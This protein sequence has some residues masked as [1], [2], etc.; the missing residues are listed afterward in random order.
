MWTIRCL[1]ELDNWDSASFI[2]L[3]YDNEHLP[4]DFSLHPEHLTQ[5]W[6]N[7]RQAI[8]GR[9]IKYYACGEYGE[10]V[11]SLR[12]WIKHGR[13]HMHAIVY[14]LD[15]Y[16]DD[17]RDLVYRC[18]SK[19]EQFMFDKNRKQNGMLPV[20]REDI[21]YTC[22]YVQK[23][24]NG[25]L[26]SEIYGDRKA[27]FSRVSHGIGLDFALKN[28]ERLINNGFTYLNGKKIAV[29][30]YFREKLGMSQ[31]EYLNNNNL[32]LETV[33]HNAAYLWNLFETDQRKKGIWN[34]D[35]LT[36][37]SYRFERWLSDFEFSL[38]KRVE[39]DYLQKKHLTSR[40][41]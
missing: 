22:G 27:P 26:G 31:R 34:P 33:E 29:P 36:M 9:K 14:G 35:N 41:I 37:T 2:T 3:T 20:C 40:Y 25:E 39:R 30:R 10:K 16:N 17:D 8:P 38:A 11:D 18:W 32:E 4:E 21:A 5:F 6:K 13:P 24:L 23:K 1:Y 28:Q 12:P 19:C 15:S 7:V